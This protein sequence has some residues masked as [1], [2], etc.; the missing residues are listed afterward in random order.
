MKIRKA[1]KKDL[2][3][4]IELFR[5]EYAKPP[6]N[7]N[8]TDKTAHAKI[9][10]LIFVAEEEKQVVGFV[11][12]NT[13][14]WCDELRGFIDEIVV[15]NKFQGRGIGKSLMKFSEDYFKKKGAKRYSL[16]SAKKSKAFKFY[17]KLGL[18]EQKDYVY[19]EKKLR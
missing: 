4:M 10:G 3:R 9:H 13:Y 1:T 5:K 8:W 15:D 17:I 16:M 11:I 2:K 18:K 6:Y 12:I 19:M 14:I 7:E